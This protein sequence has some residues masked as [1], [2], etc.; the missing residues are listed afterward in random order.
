MVNTFNRGE[1]LNKSLSPDSAGV[2]V[3][4]RGAGVPVAVEVLVG[5]GKISVIA[6]NGI[7]VV[8]GDNEGGDDGVNVCAG[9]LAVPV[10][11]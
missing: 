10:V 6:G 9:V 4:N 1:T 2:P 11:D 5:A 8:V 7:N 3:P